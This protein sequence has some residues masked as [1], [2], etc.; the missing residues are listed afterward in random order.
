[1]ERQPRGARLNHLFWSIDHDGL[2]PAIADASP[3]MTAD[4]LGI[5]RAL[6]R[7]AGDYR[8]FPGPVAE[9]NPN[10]RQLERHVTRLRRELRRTRK[11]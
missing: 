9:G 8:L 10:L 2:E 3:T 7:Y 5:V 4:A 1:M 6:V 11:K